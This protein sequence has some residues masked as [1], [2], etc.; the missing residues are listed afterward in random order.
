M[1]EKG[2]KGRKANYLFRRD[3]G[4]RGIL[5]GLSWGK[6]VSVVLYNVR[7]YSTV[8]C[9][10]LLAMVCY[11]IQY[12]THTHTQNTQT[13]I[14]LHRTSYYAC[15]LSWLGLLSLIFATQVKMPTGASLGEAFEAWYV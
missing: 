14:I 15:L 7:M 8:L 11:T 4:R 6:A 1:V 3:G 2:R 10:C 12:C 5:G 9:K 13:Y